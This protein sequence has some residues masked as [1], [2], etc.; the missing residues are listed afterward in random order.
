VVAT[1]ETIADKYL[2]YVNK[3]R[4]ANVVFSDGMK[5]LVLARG[6][7]L[8]K[9]ELDV[10]LTTDQKL[11]QRIAEEYNK[12]GIDE[13]DRLQFPIS[14][15]A[16]NTPSKFTEIHWSMVKKIWKDCVHKLEQYMKDKNRSGT[17]ESSCDDENNTNN[18]SNQYSY[19]F[20]LVSL[21][22]GIP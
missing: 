7:T 4:L 15:A 19:V 1:R 11:Y 14:I 10:G 5:D 12:E 9:D 2:G 16:K 17:N 6:K 20:L 13:Y 22:R 3:F 21:F 18:N 8:S